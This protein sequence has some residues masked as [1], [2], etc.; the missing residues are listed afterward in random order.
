M[1]IGSGWQAIRMGL[2]AAVLC[3]WIGQAGAQ[4]APSAAGGAASAQTAPAAKRTVRRKRVRTRTIPIE[5]SAPAR[6]VSG[7][8]T[9]GDAAT[10]A[11]Q[12][13]ED[14][15]V[16]AQQQARSDKEAQIT[17]DQV[18]QAQQRQ[19]AQQREV[20]IQEAPGPTQTGVVPAAGAPV[21]PGPDQRIQDQPSAVP[22]QN[23]PSPANPPQE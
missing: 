3:G 13:A 6:P 2:F 4:T 12:R 10:Q 14:A 17:N 5:A 8:P 22:G 1:E 20:R 7:M 16:L 9:T 11:Q 19:D 21:Q 23:T 18:R 15:R